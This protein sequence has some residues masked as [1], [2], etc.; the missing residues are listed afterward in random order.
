L[1]AGI[2]GSK[3]LGGLGGV[4]FTGQ[5]IGTSMGVLWALAGGFLV[6]G[7]LKV[8]TGLRMSQE[9][10]YD[11][12]DLTIHKISATPEREANW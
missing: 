10:E 2:F 4:S 11:G 8:T 12:A 7:L 6:Y 3:A 5:L 9:E 1:A